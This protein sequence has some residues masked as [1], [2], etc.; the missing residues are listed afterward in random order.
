MIREKL[1]SM[2]I[3]RKIKKNGDK[4]NGKKL[5]QYRNEPNTRTVASQTSSISCT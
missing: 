4:K 1:S 3:D 5:D 2:D